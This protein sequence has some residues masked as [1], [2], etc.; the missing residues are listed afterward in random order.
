MSGGHR[1]AAVTSGGA[2]VARGAAASPP[3]TFA[4]DHAARGNPLLANGTIPLHFYRQLAAAKANETIPPDPNE[5]FP[6]SKKHTALITHTHSD[7]F[8][9]PHRNRRHD[10]RVT[11]AGG[12]EAARGREPHGCGV[13]PGPKAEAMSG[14]HREAAVTSGGAGVARGAAASP[15]GTFAKDHAAWGNPLLANGTIPQN[16]PGNWQLATGNWHA[17]KAN[18]PIPQNSHWQLASCQCP[19]QWGNCSARLRN[20]IIPLAA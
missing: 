17:A 11:R 6:P 12:R 18:E 15:P 20:F 9:F 19:L 2:G 1:E 3:G 14:G 16:L 4:Y 7:G 5:P 8:S 10:G 13:A